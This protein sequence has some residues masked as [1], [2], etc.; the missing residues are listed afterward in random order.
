MKKMASCAARTVGSWLGWPETSQ[1]LRT[2]GDEPT[3]KRRRKQS[4]RQASRPRTL[5]Y[6]RIINIIL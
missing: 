2:R 6:L 5:I 4:R 3:M 1:E